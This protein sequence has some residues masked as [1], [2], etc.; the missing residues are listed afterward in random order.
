MFGFHKRGG[1]SLGGFWFKIRKRGEHTFQFKYYS[2][3]VCK[4]KYWRCFM[5]DRRRGGWALNLGLLY[6]KF[7]LNSL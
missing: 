3:D 7:G 4:L 2:L 5:V 1:Y 6:I